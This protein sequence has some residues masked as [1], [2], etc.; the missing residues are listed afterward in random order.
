MFKKTL[1]MAILL[2][3][4]AAL[5][6]NDYLPKFKV[7]AVV[8]KDK[9]GLNKFFVDENTKLYLTIKPLK[10][11]GLNAH[12][13]S[14]KKIIGLRSNGTFTYGILL[15]RADRTDQFTTVFGMNAQGDLMKKHMDLEDLYVD[16][17]WISW[18]EE[19]EAG[20]ILKSL[21]PE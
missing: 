2:S 5:A 6:E 18:S 12:H 15:G 19:S 3:T 10:E 21:T 11:T 17:R 13:K 4:V 8:A 7:G 14:P 1:T 16:S 20:D 9:A